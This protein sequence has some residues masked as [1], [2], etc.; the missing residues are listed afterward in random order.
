MYKKP[1]LG[2]V[3]LHNKMTEKGLTIF[4][5]SEKIGI[6]KY[7][8]V[9]MFNGYEMALTPIQIDNIKKFINDK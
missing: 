5:L 6:S 3:E 9:K 2:Y 7:K 1:I 8:L 4:W